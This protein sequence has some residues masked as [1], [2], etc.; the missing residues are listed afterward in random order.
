M[1]ELSI[2]LSIVEG[3]EEEAARCG[4]AGVRSVY[5]RLGLLAGVVKEALLFAYEQACEGTL[6]EGSQLVIE[7]VPVLVQCPVCHEPRSPHSLWRLECA[8]CDTPAA[9][10]AQGRDLQIFAMEVV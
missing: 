6:L 1:H 9:G 5:L 4:A 8:T 3:A 7:D 2:A 10:I